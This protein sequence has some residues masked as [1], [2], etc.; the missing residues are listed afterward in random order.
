MS[1][2]S[3]G[4]WGSLEST[5]GGTAKVLGVDSMVEDPECQTMDFQLYSSKAENHQMFMSR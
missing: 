5:R 1:I 2:I 4:A 3:S